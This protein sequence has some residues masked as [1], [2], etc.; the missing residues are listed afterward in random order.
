MLLVDGKPGEASDGCQ[1]TGIAQHL[2]SWRERPRTYSLT[3][4]EWKMLWK[5]RCPCLT[6]SHALREE[7]VF[8]SRGFHSGTQ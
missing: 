1:G 4:D 7:T 5:I 2:D 6:F 3:F 8:V